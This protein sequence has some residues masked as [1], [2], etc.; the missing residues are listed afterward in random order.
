MTCT[1]YVSIDL[2]NGIGFP[3]ILDYLCRIRSAVGRHYPNTSFIVYE[4]SNA[5]RL[6]VSGV[7]DASEVLQMTDKVSDEFHEPV[8]FRMETE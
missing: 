4:D 3:D 7:S 8:V 5:L 2:G 6:D 1:A